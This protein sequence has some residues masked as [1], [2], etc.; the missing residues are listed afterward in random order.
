MISVP[1]NGNLSLLGSG[2]ADSTAIAYIL[3]RFYS[4][5]KPK[6]FMMGNQ[7][8]HVN[9][10]RKIISYIKDSTGYEYEFVL[11]REKGL[12]RPTVEKILGVLGGVVYTGCNKVVTHFTPTVYIEGD[13]PPIRGPSLNEKHIRP[14]IDMDKV[15]ILQIYKD[16]GILDLLNMTRSCGLATGIC[17][18]CYFCMERSWACEVLDIPNI[19]D[20]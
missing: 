2:G 3:A 17:E 20:K 7:E 6:I 11:F 14:F 12:I 5:R 4:H 18:G 8:H 1:E 13:T 15:Q 16:H 10:L 19:Q 9:R